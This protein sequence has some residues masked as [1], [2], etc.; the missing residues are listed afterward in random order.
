MVTYIGTSGGEVNTR[1][2]T[3]P[4]LTVAAESQPLT[5][6]VYRTMI[7]TYVEVNPGNNALARSVTGRVYTIFCG[8]PA[9][10]GPG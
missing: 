2:R 6:G 1:N 3:V 10:H 9:R 5:G 8:I 4:A 7:R